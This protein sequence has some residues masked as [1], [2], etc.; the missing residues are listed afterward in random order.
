MRAVY[1]CALFAFGCSPKEAPPPT[2]FVQFH[3]QLTPDG[4]EK[5]VL[6]PIPPGSLPC[7]RQAKEIRVEAKKGGAQV[8]I[9]LRDAATMPSELQASTVTSGSCQCRF[10]GG[11]SRHRSSQ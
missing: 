5:D 10:P 8:L 7:M 9:A 11:T 3:Y 6:L 1:L 4:T 2:E